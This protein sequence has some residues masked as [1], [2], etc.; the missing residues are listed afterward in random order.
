M[1]VFFG[2]GEPI[3]FL[4]DQSTFAHVDGKY[5]SSTAHPVQVMNQ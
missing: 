5:R 4:F 3:S 2:I 1:E